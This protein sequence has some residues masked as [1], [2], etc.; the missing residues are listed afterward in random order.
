MNIIPNP[1]RKHVLRRFPSVYSSFFLSSVLTL[2][3]HLFLSLY[4]L[5]FFYLWLHFSIFLYSFLFCIHFLISFLS[6]YHFSFILPFAFIPLSPF[7]PFCPHFFVSISFYLGFAAPLNAGNQ[8]VFSADLQSV[9]C[10]S[11]FLVT[12]NH[13]A[14][15]LIQP[16]HTRVSWA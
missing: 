9:R 6:S 14:A 15:D 1:T 11:K 13:H 8:I 4:L 7:L 2:F 3:L 12:A 10:F 5:S 16:R